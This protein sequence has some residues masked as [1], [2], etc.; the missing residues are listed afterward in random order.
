[1]V[2]ITKTIQRIQGI[3]RSWSNKYLWHESWA[4]CKKLKP[5]YTERF[6]HT[7]AWF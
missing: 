6:F 4:F 7:L 1:M 3:L 5:I 2:K